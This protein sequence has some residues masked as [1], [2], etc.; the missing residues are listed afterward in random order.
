MADTID[1]VNDLPVEAF[2]ALPE[3]RREERM[4]AMTPMQQHLFRIRLTSYTKERAMRVQSIA[5]RRSI[6]YQDPMPIDRGYVFGARTPREAAA[7]L[8]EQCGRQVPVMASRYSRDGDG[9][10]GALALLACYAEYAEAVEKLSDMAEVLRYLES[11]GFS[12][13]KS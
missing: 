3:E 7:R 4:A 9:A 2:L 1:S 11:I 12:L 13:K 10:I 8:L 5:K 6:D